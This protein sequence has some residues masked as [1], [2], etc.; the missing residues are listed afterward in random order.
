MRKPL[1]LAIGTLALAAISGSAAAQQPF[2]DQNQWQILRDEANGTAP[3][4]N[5]RALTRLHRVPATA[6]FDE[7]AAQILARAQEY[8]LADAHQER[9]AANGELH[10]GLMR[11]HMGWNVKRASLWR[12]QPD[13]VLMGDWASDPIRLADYSHTADIETSVVDVGKGMA[14]VDYEGKDVK[15]RIVLADG[16]L[17]VVQ[18]LAVAKYGAAGIVSDQPNQTSA[19]SGLDPTL[20]RWGHLDTD[21]PK[22]F[23][24]MVSKQEMAHLRSLP[25][26]IL[27]AKVEAEVVP[28]AWSVVTGTI[29]GADPSAG[30]VVY[31]CHLDH[32]RPGANDNGSGCV[33]ILESARILQKL[34]GTGKLPRPARTIRFIWGPEVEGTMAFLAQHR[35]I[36]KAMRADIHMDMVGGDFLKNKSML[37]VTETPWSLPSFVSD[38]GEM[39]AEAIKQGAYRY[40]AGETGPEDAV[41]D[42]HGS[43]NVFIA[44]VTPYEEGSDHDDYD[45]STIAVPSIYLRDW[46]DIYIHTDHDS[47]EQI[48]PT[49]LRRVALLGAASGY[50]LA[51]VTADRAA[52]ILPVLTARSQERLS[53]AFQKAKAMESGYEARN[54]M[55]HAHQRELQTVRSFVAYSHAGADLAQ[56][57]A[58][59]DQQAKWLENWL[60]KEA[61]PTWKRSPDAAL[62]PKRIGEFGPLTFQNDDV[63]V[64]RLG[65]ERVGQIKLLGLDQGRHY[66]YEVVN[67]V[68][69]RR[70]IGEIRDSVSAEFGPISLELVAEYLRACEE[71]KVVSF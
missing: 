19:W 55:I 14:E 59:I 64:D 17:P 28:G 10:Y 52:A 5:L 45:S 4:E 27:A 66:A 15:G 37:H 41:L 48:D 57:E 8:G 26:V 29:L 24:F 35:D 49:K 54:L 18:R 43:R 12:T 11:S 7:A 23:A 36:M 22:G 39:L 13:H 71:A 68:D 69:G 40:A 47:L 44:D 33:T 9:F 38:V 70:S 62:V 42:E 53:A 30:E 61:A 34:I 46:P 51:S 21:Q 63:L 6:A 32:E 1:L 16:A 25:N 50:A 2:L 3:Y 31:S 20:V 67:F 60:P 58:A 65:R 56:Y